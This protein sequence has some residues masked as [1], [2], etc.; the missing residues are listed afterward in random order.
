MF[1]QGELALADFPVIAFSLCYEE[2]YLDAAKALVAAEIPL[3]RDERP[4]FPIVMAGGPLACLT[5]APFLPALD[6]LFV[7]EAEAGLA[8]VCAVMA[9]TALGSARPQAARSVSAP[10]RAGLSSCPCVSKAALMPPSAMTDWARSE[11]REEQSQTC[12]P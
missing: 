10:C 2:E 6:L 1:G 5:P 3:R 8:D 9:R 7:G 4:D 12:Q 11:G